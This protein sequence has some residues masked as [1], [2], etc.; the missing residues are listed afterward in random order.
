MKVVIEAMGI[1]NFGGGRSATLNLLEYLFELD[2]SNEYTVILT[3]P[4]PTL[5]KFS[6]NVKQLIAPTA[7]RFLSRLWMQLISPIRFRRYDLIH[8]TKNL[9][10][11][12]LS[13]PIILTIFD[14]SILSY[15]EFFPK[16]D[17]FYW[18]TFEKLSARKANRIIAISKTTAKD[19]EK[20]YKVPPENIE[21]IYPG[22][23]N[24]YKPSTESEVIRVL[25]KYNLK[26]PYIICVGRIDRKKNLSALVKA[27]SL[28]KQRIH[29]QGKLVI[30]G[31]E[32][33]KSKDTALKSTIDNLEIGNEV[34]LTGRVPNE[35]LPPL[36]TGA[37][38]CAF[39]SIHEGFGLV[40]L[41][42]LACGTPLIAHKSNAV[43]EVVGN[44]GILV[45]ATDPTEVADKMISV[46][47]DPHLRKNLSRAGLIRA[48]Q[49]RWDTAAERLLQNYQDIYEKSKR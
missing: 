25:E 12:G 48:L 13:I 22:R 24:H 2:K 7:N 47:Q 33:K 10:V 1:Q 46:I 16:I 14:L 8:F 21:L 44:A 11:F 45:D 39:P 6:S 43:A 29:Y 20:F 40:A 19:L 38:L 32:Y 18:K 5:Q 3:K 28:V 23:D 31:E 37:H 27:F 36:Y 34:V 17:V 9:G 4:E 41:E 15:P 35:D 49:F 26:E 42:A 30:V